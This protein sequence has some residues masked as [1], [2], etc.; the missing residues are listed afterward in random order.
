MITF[1]A[2]IF[3][4]NH[5]NF[6]LANVR[7]KYG[8][9]TGAVGIVLNVFLC[10]LKFFAGALV[11]SIAITADAV[12]NL[13]DAT[14]SVITLVG[15]KLSGKTPDHGHPFGHGRIEYL[16]GLIVS[17]LVLFT[18]F[19][20]ALTSFEKILSPQNVDYSPIAIIILLLSIAVKLYM[21]YYNN[22]IGK[23]IESKALLATALDSL[24][25][26]FATG[27]VLI[28]AAASLL[29]GVSFDGVGGLVIAVFIVFMGIKSAKDILASILGEPPSEQLVED[30][31][32][33]VL[34]NKTIL[35]MHDL[36][37]HDYGPGRKIVTL[38]AEVD[39]NGNFLELHELIDNIEYKLSKHLG[40][41]TTIHLDPIDIDN[42]VIAKWK[43]LIGSVVIEINDKLTVHDVRT[44]PGK[45]HTNIIFDVVTP[46]GFKMKDEKLINLISSKID[47]IDNRY[48]CIIKV[49][50]SYI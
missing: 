17:I 43:E 35:G 14:S 1:L 42:S 40:C 9:V 20:I 50:K 6:K 18:G 37:V 44:V 30:I 25:D 29:F 12:N 15:F 13:L 33:I 11:G 21:A 2:R 4:K 3:I 41:E 47:K 26:S 38:H 36:I 46:K 8:V 45:S 23:K 49:D 48:H 39:G 19:E 31:K 32:N 5:K 27:V 10:L 16:T 7:E 34:E 28:S 24:G 22:S